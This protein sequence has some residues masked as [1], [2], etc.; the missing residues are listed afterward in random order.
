[1]PLGQ[2][3]VLEVDGQQVHQ[4]IAI[5]RYVAKK[6]GLAGQNDWESLLIDVVVDT[7][8]DFSNSKCD[9]L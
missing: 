2:V 8:S 1:M 3:P 7:I 6:V 9:I 5:A 4:S